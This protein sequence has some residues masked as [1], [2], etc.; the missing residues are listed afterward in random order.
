MILFCCINHEQAQKQNQNKSFYFQEK[1]AKPV[2]T[3]DLLYLTWLLHY[4][5][6]FFFQ[7]NMYLPIQKL[8]LKKKKK[9]QWR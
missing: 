2:H 4:A 6:W 1:N 7:K 9:I 8:N 3:D 5:L